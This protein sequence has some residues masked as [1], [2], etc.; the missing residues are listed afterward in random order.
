MTYASEGLW[1]WD[2]LNNTYFVMKAFL[3][4]ILADQLGSAKLNRLVGHMGRHGDRFSMV[5]SA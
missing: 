1:I 2:T 4:L 5:I 3:V